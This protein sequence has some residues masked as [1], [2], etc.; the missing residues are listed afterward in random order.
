M[1]HHTSR[2]AARMAT[3]AAAACFG[4]GFLPSAAH[5]ESKKT[6]K[7]VEVVPGEFV[8]ELDPNILRESGG[9]SAMAV[10]TLA[11]KLGAEVVEQVRPEMVLVRASDQSA[12]GSR[13]LELR[14]QE[15]AYVRRVEPNYVYTTSKLPNDP[16]LAKTWGLKNTGAADSENNMGRAGVDVSAEQAWDITTGSKS[17]VVAVIDSGIDFSHPDLKDQAWV[18]EKELNG[19]PGVDDDGNGYIDDIHGYDF[20]GNK[21]DSTDDNSHGTHCAGTI[22][23]KGNDGRG[24]VGVNW[25][26]SMMGV[27]FLDKQG[28]GSLANAIK[29]IDY[30]RKMGARIMSNS[31]GGGAASDLLK[32]AIQEAANDGI[33]F[34]AAAGND[35][36]DND[37]MPS[38]PASYEVDNVLSV[39]AIDNRG[40]LASFS[41]YGAKSV[42]VAAPGVNII[43]TVPGGKY[44]SYSGTSM[45]TP[46]VSGIAALLLANNGNLTY[47]ELKKTI[48]DSSR[49]LYTL[50]RRVASA[51]MADAYYALSGQTPPADPND[52]SR[53]KNVSAYAFSSEHPYKE[54][55]K[56]EHKIRIPGAKKI[57]VRFSKFETEIGYDTLSFYDAKG[58]FVGSLSGTQDPGVTSQLIEGDSV[59]L[60][61]SADETVSGY[62]FDIEGI[63]WE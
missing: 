15:N 23:A 53:L 61:F 36:N 54:G 51:G 52:P 14:L 18:N 7:P 33:L 17:V 46:H 25:D 49:P 20:A 22:G 56:F 40:A 57:A 30:A 5:A 9:I 35:A 1:F 2:R 47:R 8:V 3:L 55:A 16:D 44:D 60:K 13:S 58:S 48:M 31:W 24:L 50:R 10:Q 26:V 43:S 38:Y 42:H 63:L 37:A 32:K 27:K 62:G 11:K 59:T 12:V 34:V 29:S 21:G 6:P 45:A 41:N 28:R 19:L 39:A 4:L